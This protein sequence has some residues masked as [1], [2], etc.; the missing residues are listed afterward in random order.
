MVVGSDSGWITGGGC[1]DY[2]NTY[3]LV[4]ILVWVH[5]IQIKILFIRYV[6]IF[7]IPHRKFITFRKYLRFKR[8]V[9]TGW[10]WVTVWINEW[11]ICLEQSNDA[12]VAKNL[13]TETK[14]IILHLDLP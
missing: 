9:S 3:I 1:V 7:I 8:L 12:T 10:H 2:I 5:T 6:D 4:T 11:A 13:W 14:P